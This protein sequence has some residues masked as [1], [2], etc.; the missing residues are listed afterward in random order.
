M[1]LNY[2]NKL[3]A[4]FAFM[5]KWGSLI[6]LIPLMIYF[7]ANRGTFFFIDYLNLLVHEG[8]HGIFGL[9]GIRFITVAG[10]TIMQLLIPFLFVFSFWIKRQSIGTQFSLVWLGQ[11]FINVSVYAA[12]AVEQKLPLIGGLSKAHHDWSYL[13]FELGILQSASEVGYFFY[14]IAILIFILVVIIPLIFNEGKR[15]LYL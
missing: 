5:K 9:F 8:G 2:L 13:L 15:V 3:D 4:F 10:G 12:D 6:I 7:A 11:N 14:I 1:E